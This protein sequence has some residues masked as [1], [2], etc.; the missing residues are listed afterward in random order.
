VRRVRAAL[1][2]VAALGWVGADAAVSQTVS[3]A[4]CH[5][6]RG[7]AGSD[8]AGRAAYAKACES[9]HG[10]EGHGGTAPAL[11]PFTLE[12]SELI[13]IV[14]QGIGVMPGIPRDRISDEEISAIRDYLVSLKN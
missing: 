4:V 6:V 8:S 7:T 3:Q 14:R 2:A 13:A 11:V 1:I 5:T 12:L 10:P 9:C